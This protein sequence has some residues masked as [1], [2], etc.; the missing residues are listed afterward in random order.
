[1]N[2]SDIIQSLESVNETF[3]FN[4]AIRNIES[5][6]EGEINIDR[7]DLSGTFPNWE[8]VDA[9]KRLSIITQMLINRKMIPSDKK[10][11]IKT[12]RDDNGN[13]KITEIKYLD[14]S[15]EKILPRVVSTTLG[16]PNGSKIEL[17]QQQQQDVN[18]K[19]LNYIY[20]K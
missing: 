11:I 20:N 12:M 8:D 3:I 14:K 7:I 9:N 13:G 6:Q 5:A 2:F 15:N 17:T 1:M 10:I 4:P 18:R 19:N 16:K